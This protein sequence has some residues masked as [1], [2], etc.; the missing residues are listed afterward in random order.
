MLV[1]SR[2]LH[3]SIRIGK[4]ITITVVDICGGTVRLGITAPRDVGI[5]RGE[6]GLYDPAKAPTD[7]PRASTSP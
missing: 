3:E 5:T 2:R 1:L 6:L 7:A 4:D